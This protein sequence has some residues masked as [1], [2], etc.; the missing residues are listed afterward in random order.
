[1]Q[2]AISEEA[3]RRFELYH[4]LRTPYYQASTSALGKLQDLAYGRT[5]M[6][7][8]PGYLGYQ[9]ETA[10]GEKSLSRTA[11]AKRHLFSGRAGK[12]MTRYG[13][14]QANKFL[15]EKWGELFRMAFTPP[16]IGWPPMGIG[17]RNLPDFS[18]TYN[19]GTP[20]SGGESGGAPAT[21]TTAPRSVFSGSDPTDPGT[22]SGDYGMKFEK[23]QPKVYDPG[24][25]SW[26]WL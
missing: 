7:D 6:S 10:E 26:T 23:G 12:E 9:M 21:P 24:T 19:A 11:A 4:G 8:L 20:V 17:G 18:N 2:R 5:K 22:Y 1:M 15:G 16:A 3:Q 14:G 25:D 13:E